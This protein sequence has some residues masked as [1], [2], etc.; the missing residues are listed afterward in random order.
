MGG[1]GGRGTAGEGFGA[2][3]R[4]WLTVGCLLSGAGAVGLLWAVRAAQRPGLDASALA[5]VLSFGTSVPGLLVGL[6][7]L[8]V[9]WEGYRADRREAADGVQLSAVAD[10]LAL[11]LRNTWSTEAKVRQVDGSGALTVSWLPAPAELTE[12][13]QRISGTATSWPSSAARDPRTWAAHPGGLGG[14]GPRR[15][16]EVFAQV[17]TRRLIL[18]GRE[19]SGKSV[20]LAQLPR[21]LLE[22]RDTN[23]PE[24]VPVLL[25]LASWD[26]VREP[27]LFAWMDRRLARDFEFLGPPAPEPQR[28][29]S[30]ARALLDSRYLLPVLDGFDEIKESFRMEALRRINA[31]LKSGQGIVLACRT[32][33]Y[34]GALLDEPTDGGARPAPLSGAAGIELQDLTAESVRGRL[35]EGDDALL[36]ERW[37]PVT[38]QLHDASRP[39]TGALATPLMVSLA[40]DIH[41]PLPGD[42]VARFPSPADLVVAPT[43]GAP[44]TRGEIEDMLLSGVLPAAYAR[45]DEGR[46][47]RWTTAQ[48]E[49]TLTLLARHLRNNLNG[50]TD[51]EWWALRRTAPRI[52]HSFVLGLPL[53]VALAVALAVLPASDVPWWQVA[54]VGVVAGGWALGTLHAFLTPKTE[55]ADRIRVSW[56]GVAATAAVCGAVAYREDPGTAVLVVPLVLLAVFLGF[57]WKATKDAD[58]MIALDPLSLL[59]RDRRA[60][61]TLVIGFPLLAA[62]LMTGLLVVGSVVRGPSVFAG[63]PLS[64]LGSTL[65]GLLA[66]GLYS[67]VLVAF[68]H[69][70]SPAL[71]ITCWYLALRHGTPRD[72]MA[73]LANAHQQRAVLRRVGAVY[74][75]RH[76]DLQRHLADHRPD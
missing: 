25:S 26:P 15:L 50:T 44:R 13:W 43:T 58:M 47:A 16:A 20:L 45:Y 51:I 24:P 14:T 6:A 37:R 36:T 22:S 48:A 12:S 28:S 53:W 66:L 39:V 18:L 31:A 4:L 32:A 75:F 10:S 60:A 17:P 76:L 46:P 3:R 59:A 63:V 65:A 21:Q 64:E 5:G 61:R 2:R 23:S 56:P 29:V 62:L 42:V 69:T 27:D 9:A 54:M 71:S 57:G 30:R 73:F 41:N 1:F 67:G 68:R 11:A 74:Q 8:G 72:L 49:R 52:V 34:R 33:D 7:S 40:V 19:G 38:E 55:P 35:C 70:A